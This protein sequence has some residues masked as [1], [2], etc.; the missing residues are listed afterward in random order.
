MLTVII[1]CY[2]KT[3]AVQMFGRKSVAV[4]ATLSL[5][6]YTK[7][8]HTTITALSFTFLEYPDGSEVA[9][10]LCDGKVRYLQR[11][12]YSIVSGCHDSSTVAISS[13]HSGS[14]FGTV[15]SG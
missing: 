15:D 10:W 5:L 2:Y 7:L 6:S 8:L 9:M 1:L 4:L 12:T 11:K 13:V 3:W 14:L